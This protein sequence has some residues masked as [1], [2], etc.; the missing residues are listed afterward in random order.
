[1]YISANGLEKVAV[2]RCSP[3]SLRSQ[4][5][6]T[7]LPDD[8]ERIV[9]PQASD[10]HCVSSE[11]NL[12][13]NRY[14]NRIDGRVVTQT[15]MHV[16]DNV[17]WQALTT[18]QAQFSECF[19]QARRFV[20]EVTSLTAFEEESPQGY[21][22]LAGL[23]GDGGTAALFLASEYQ[24]RTGWELIAGA[25]LLEMV[26]ENGTGH[27]QLSAPDPE[28]IRLDPADSP[29]MVELATLTKPGPFSVR[30]HELGTYVGI[31]HDGKLVAMAGERLKVP[32][33]TEVSAV[34]THPEH[35][36]KGYARVLITE[37]MRGI[38][39]RGEIPFLHVRRDNA[40]AV[41]LYQRLGF[42]TRTVPHYAVLRRLKHNL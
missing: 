36:G 12:S 11:F 25:P 35:L 10:S 15:F 38:A 18:R 7:R 21:A 22:A 8:R 24:P 2:P 19:G 29:E 13:L 32:G 20:R 1:M 39:D 40:R 4:F 23:V 26:C 34:C 31:R 37:I 42:R 27:E 16:L 33:Y 28:V 9:C 41:A 5:S 30:T 6:G 3:D 17:I 14:S